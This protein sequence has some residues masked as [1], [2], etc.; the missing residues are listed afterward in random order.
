MATSYYKQ[1]K[2]TNGSEIKIPW[3]IKQLISESNLDIDLSYFTIL[4]DNTD[5]VKMK[6]TA[7]D[8]EITKQ[9]DAIQIV[10]KEL[11]WLCWNDKIYT[12][13]NHDYIKVYQAKDNIPILISKIEMILPS[14]SEP[15]YK[16]KMLRVV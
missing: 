3:V 5:Y 1:I 12:N 7:H 2:T 10:H 4:Q 11:F 16:L 9:I 14:S 15:Y 8:I 6:D 13:Q